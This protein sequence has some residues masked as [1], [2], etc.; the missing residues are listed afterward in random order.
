MSSFSDPAAVAAYADNVVRQVPALH[1]LHRMAGILLGEC[2]PSDGRVLVLGAG[3]GMELKAFAQAHADW[4]FVG[5]DP[6]SEMLA[7]AARTL[8]PLAA[9]TELVHGFIDAAPEIAFDGASCLLTLHFLARDERLRTLH[10][11]RRRLKPGAALVIAHHSVPDAI[12]DKR[13]WFRRH[14]A[15]A[16]SN[17]TPANG[18][19]SVAEALASR[20]PTLSPESEVALLEEAGFMRPSLFYAAFTLRG[21]VAYAGK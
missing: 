14:A 11:I 5:V 21:W 17:G 1:A 4:R 12:D 2:V 6:S 15:F 19:E 7:L 18:M 13:L 8:G 20:L 10:E 9:R 3:G 16:A